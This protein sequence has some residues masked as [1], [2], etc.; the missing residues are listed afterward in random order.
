MSR[1]EFIS[2]LF[3]LFNEM[4]ESDIDLPEPDRTAFIGAAKDLLLALG[5]VWNERTQEYIV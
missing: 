4:H 3:N 1:Q 2:R 5:M